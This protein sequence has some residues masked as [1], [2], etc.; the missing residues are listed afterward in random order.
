MK[1]ALPLILWFSLTVVVAILGCWLAMNFMADHRHL[2]AGEAHQWVHDQLRITA[3]QE[4]RLGPMEKRYEDQKRH[5]TE[6]MRLANRELAEAILV[7]KGSSPRVKTAV[8][9]IHEAM[10]HLQQATLDHVFEMK[11]VL[12]AE[13]YEKLL[14]LT[15]NGLYELNHEH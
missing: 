1:R 4:E 8:A 9:T 11:E 10:G 14:N 5:Y 12:T 3:E 7:D 15:A 6:L 2:S 13:Q